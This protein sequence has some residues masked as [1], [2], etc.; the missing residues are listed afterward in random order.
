MKALTEYVFIYPTIFENEISHDESLKLVFSEFPY[1]RNYYAIRRV[2]PF[3]FVKDDQSTL[4][5]EK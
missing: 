3:W 4:L 5:S 1:S 2:K